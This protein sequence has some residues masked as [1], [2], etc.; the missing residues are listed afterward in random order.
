MAQ[1]REF[2][3]GELRTSNSET[4]RTLFCFILVFHFF[5]SCFLIQLWYFPLSSKATER[6]KIAT[7]E[8]GVGVRE[9]GVFDEIKG[10]MDCSS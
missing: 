5:H 3:L 2:I 10:N 1:K 4:I 8:A 7:K 6:K 9:V